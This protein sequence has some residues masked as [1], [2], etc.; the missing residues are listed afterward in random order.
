[1]IVTALLLVLIAL[2]LVA[3]FYA[4]RYTWRAW[5]EVRADW[6]RL[7]KNLRDAWDELRHG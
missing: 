5:L 2:E 7:R 4:V 1:M 6:P 3:L